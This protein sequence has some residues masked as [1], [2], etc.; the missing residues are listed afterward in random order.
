MAKGVNLVV[1][2]TVTA[3]AAFW[4]YGRLPAQYNPFAPLS[5]D[6]PPT[7]VTRYK[8]RQMDAHPEACFALLE[9]AQNRKLLGYRTVANVAGDCPL[10]N[11]VRVQSFGDVQLSSSFLASCPLALSSTMF[12]HQR[13]APQARAEYGSR[14]TRINH[15]DSYACRNIYNRQEGR[16][17]EHATAD[18]LDISGFSFAN[19]HSV[20]V[21]KGWR[22]TG[23]GQQYLHSVFKSGCP[24]FGNALGPDYNA[25]HANHFHMGMR[26]YGLCR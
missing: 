25:A 14:L 18:A 11:V 15:L 4:L 6:D 9:Q 7:L 24:F 16:L 26:G 12:V 20:S 1:G 13:A 5:L 23:R 10:A 19:G 22:A 3:L 2:L 8:L 21:L 17:S